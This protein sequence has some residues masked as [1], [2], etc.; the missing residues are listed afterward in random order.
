ML[1]FSFFNPDSRA[2][3]TLR[4]DPPEVNISP[5]LSPQAQSPVAASPGTTA[6]AAA[7]SPVGLRPDEAETGVALRTLQPLYF[8]PGFLVGQG[9]L[10]LG[11]LGAGLWLRRRDRLAA[12]QG[13]ALRRRE[14][15]AVDGFLSTMDAAA[16]RHDA[17]T[18]FFSARQALQH[19]LGWRWNTAP[20]AVTV[21]EIDAHLGGDGENVRRV[22][23]LA[24][25]LAYSSGESIDADFPAW[26]KTVHQL[27]KQAET[28]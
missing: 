28:L 23:A 11:F 26:K 18:F 5:G 17:A 15:K 10:V 27:I 4:T 25:Q 19:C 8:Q 12:D 24:D 14:L 7:A 13:H 21:A 22:F 16:S 6:M 2:Y 9:L 20:A 3:E 1:F